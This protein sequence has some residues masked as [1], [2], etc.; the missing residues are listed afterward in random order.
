MAGREYRTGMTLAELFKKFPDNAAAEAWFVETRWPNGVAC[1]A[2]GSLNIQTRPTRKPQPYRCRDCRKDF[3]VKLGTLMEGSNLGLQTWAIALYLLTT[4]IKGTSSL[5]LH[6][7]LG[8][9][10]KSAWH[11]AHRIRETW[12]DEE[13]P[14]AGPVEADETYVGGLEKN[15]HS[16]KRL[17]Q[18]SGTA[19][20]TTVAGVKDRATGHVSAAVVPATNAATLVPFVEK[21]TAHEA[22]VY[23]D[24]HSAYSP[25]SYHQTVVHSVGE[26]VDGQA[27]TNGIESFWSLLKR[28]Y[29]GTFH[30][31][32][33]KH[34]DRYVTEFA[35]RYN[36][37]PLDTIHQMRDM[38]R[39]MVGK[40]LTYEELIK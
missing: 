24:E 26:Y 9:T 31:I 28:G 18:G 35:G 10:Q 3:S 6:R 11:L 19:G 38:V 23:T 30:Q 34:L 17:H 15:K 25:L 21:R 29:H 39:G 5:K 4:G 12:H 13:A 37:R 40:R 16:Y 36:D 8:I 2:C 14:F 22:T 32:S 33:P 7:D 27:H 20:K 1:S